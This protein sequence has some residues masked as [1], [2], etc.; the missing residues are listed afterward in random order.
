MSP[1]LVCGLSLGL[2]SGTSSST[3]LSLKL[4][5]HPVQLRC[6]LQAPKLPHA[7]ASYTLM[8]LNWLFDQLDGTKRQAG[9]PLGLASGAGTE[10][11]SIKGG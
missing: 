4:P 5:W 10:Q 1:S 2:E 3:T 11:V 8:T 6:L 9:V 7:F